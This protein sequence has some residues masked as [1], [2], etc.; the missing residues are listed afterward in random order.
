M[1]KLMLRIDIFFYVSS[2]FPISFSAS[3][4]YTPTLRGKSVSVRSG[5]LPLPEPLQSP[6]PSIGP[7]LGEALWSLQHCYC[8]T[9]PLSKLEGFIQVCFCIW[10]ELM[11]QMSK[12]V[13][14]R[15]QDFKKHSTNCSFFFIA[16][17]ESRFF[18][19]PC[20]IYGA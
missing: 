9:C 7:N 17:G 13:R 20:Q 1:P 10:E 2:Y 8:L 14:G 3:V 19:L 12:M 11:V 18:I 6:G 5:D 15:Q 16:G 4:L